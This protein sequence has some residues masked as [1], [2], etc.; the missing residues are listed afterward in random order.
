MALAEAENEEALF[1][2]WT[3]LSSSAQAFPVT[4]SKQGHSK[5][6]NDFLRGRFGRKSN[7]CAACCLER[8]RPAE[9]RGSSAGHGP[10]PAAAGGSGGGRQNGKNLGCGLQACPSGCVGGRPLSQDGAEPMGAAWPM[11]GPAG[12][13]GGQAVGSLRVPPH[14]APVLRG[15]CTPGACVSPGC[16]HCAWGPREDGPTERGAVGTRGGPGP[17]SVSSLG[18]GSASRSTAGIHALFC[19]LLYFTNVLKHLNNEEQSP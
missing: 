9:T 2:A 19:T 14:S 6:T 10:E 16:S 1:S 4:Q 8:R 18:L 11:S 12:R 15:S 13:Q 5:L 17:P 7:P 3:S